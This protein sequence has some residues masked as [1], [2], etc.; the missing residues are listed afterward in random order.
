MRYF[1]W[2]IALTTLS[3]AQ[4]FK[5]MC[6]MEN[7]SSPSTI[8]QVKMNG[9]K[10]KGEKSIEDLKKEGWDIDDIITKETDKGISYMYIMQKNVAE[11]IVE[12][13]IN[14]PGELI[15]ANKQKILQFK[16]QYV[17]IKNA[18]D[19]TAQIDIGNLKVGQSGVIMHKYKN[20]YAII[21]ASA[22]VTQTSESGSTIEFKNFDG[23]SQS[24]LPTANIKAS[25]GDVLIL[26]Y[27]YES[28]M[29]IAPNVQGFKTVRSMFPEQNFVHSDLFA[30]TL[31]YMQ[32]STP[33]QAIIQAFAKNQNIGTIFVIIDSMI[34]M[35]DAKS[36]K[37]LSKYP[38]FY[39][40]SD[41]QT[42]F[43]TRIEDIKDGIFSLEFIGWSDNRMKDY[44][45]YYSEMLGM[46][47]DYEY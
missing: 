26:N 15:A 7:W 20:K 30:A 27:M 45:A 3:N 6:F 17:K 42:P 22:I 23:L 37:V 29:V 38:I 40:Q 4:M 32:K 12:R 35:L 44:S 18:N 31:K 16:P 13:I 2:L 39:D 28:S 9:G 41:V 19:K 1:I 47:Y 25:D 21:I 43:Y 34:Y 46:D 5:T 33:N 8:E 10:C 11:S 14:N 24:G 36:F